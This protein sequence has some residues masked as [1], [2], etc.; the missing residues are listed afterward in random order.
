MKTFFKT[1]ESF[2]LR[3]LNP[4]SVLKSLHICSN[5]YK[6]A[7]KLECSVKEFN[8]KLKDVS[9]NTNSSSIG[10]RHKGQELLV[11]VQVSIQDLQKECPQFR[12]SFCRLLLPKRHTEHSKQLV[13]LEQYS[14]SFFDLHLQGRPLRVIAWQ[15]IM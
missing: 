2:I 12:V 7:L 3:Y 14:E 5:W 9:I 10:L 8:K 1:T 13:C 6:A 15:D 4:E 11:L